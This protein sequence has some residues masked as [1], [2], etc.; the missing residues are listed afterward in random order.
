MAP[1]NCSVSSRR[2]TSSNLTNTG[3]SGNVSNVSHNRPATSSPRNN[4]NNSGKRQKQQQQ[5]QRPQ[6]GLS[7]NPAKDAQQRQQSAGRGKPGPN[8][9]KSEDGA[10]PKAKRSGRRQKKIVLLTRDASDGEQQSLLAR[11]APDPPPPSS[12]RRSIAGGNS[13]PG[14]GKRGRQTSPVVED[15]HSNQ[16][17]HTPTPKQQQQQQQTVQSVLYSPTP[18]RAG[19]GPMRGGSPGGSAR[20]NHYAGASFNNSP[21]P[22]TLPLPP[23]FLTTPT[24]STPRREAPLAMRD[25]DVFGM[26]GGSEY[27]MH[28]PP[29]ALV[30][31]AF[32]ERT[33]HLQSMLDPATHAML[34]PPPVMQQPY[35]HSHSAVDLSHQY[36]QD[37]DME[38]MFQKL[39]LA[40][41]LAQKRPAT[42]NPVTSVP[43]NN[44]SHLT[45][46]H[47]A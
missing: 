27:S 11:L 16:R 44:N 39:R 37:S 15:V 45:P 34:R 43:G 38:S 41:D 3:S 23:S 35:N 46:V 6:R 31:P 47:N 36:P 14:T 12:S 42:V 32:D 19:S 7:T 1:H 22:N 24:K 13:S 40:M 17:M 30:A 25:E 5:Q 26:P 8:Q 29:P 10:R 2:M 33:R 21:A 28:H 20:S 9:R 18:R 4:N